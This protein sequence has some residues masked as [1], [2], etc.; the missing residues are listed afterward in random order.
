[1]NEVL[2]L[3][4]TAALPEKGLH[5]TRPVSAG[6]AAHTSGL[7]PWLPETRV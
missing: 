6:H 3:L 1:M 5:R 4:A 2:S 7:I